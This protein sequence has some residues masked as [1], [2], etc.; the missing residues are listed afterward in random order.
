MESARAPSLPAL[1]SP[2]RS[3]RLLDGLRGR[4][5]SALLAEGLLGVAVGLAAAALLSFSLDYLLALPRGVRLVFLLG[6]AA[7]LVVALRRL[8]KV[9]RAPLSDQDLATIVERANPELSQA[10]LTAVE[11]SASANETAA[12]VSRDMVAAVVRDVEERIQGARVDGVLDARGQR[13]K[14]AALGVLLAVGFAGVLF[15]GDLVAIWLRRNLLLGAERWP[16]HTQ[17]VLVS[18]AV[19]DG[20]ILVAMGDDL[21]VIVRA[22]RGSPGSVSLRTYASGSLQRTDLLSP[23]A[24]AEYRALIENVSRPFSFVVQGGDDEIGPHEVDVRLRPRIDA[25]SIE[26]WCEYPAYT[27]IPPTPAAEPLRFANLK[28]PAGTKARY[29]MAASVPIRR[30]FFVFRPAPGASEGEG[31]VGGREAVKAGA[32]EPLAGEWP[33]QGAVELTVVEGKRFEGELD[34]THS[35]QYFFQLEAVDGFRSVRPDR[36]RVEA[37]P[38]LKPQARILEPERITEEVS[39]E[40]TIPVRVSA[41]DDYGLKQV[42]LEGRYFHPGKE[43]GVSQSFPF[44]RLTLEGRPPAED[45]EAAP[46]P[47]GA[48]TPAEDEVAIKIAALNTGGEGTVS[49]GARLQIYAL[50]ADLAGQIGESQIHFLN[51]V[52]QDDLLRILTDQ[53]MVVRDQLREVLRRQK[54]A[55][56]DLEDFQ[57]QIALLERIP[58]AEARRLGM[59][60]QDQERVTQ[61]TLREAQELSRVLARAGR[62]QVGDEK[63]RS[64]VSGVRDDVVEI[65]ERRSAGV[66]GM[67][68]TLQDEAT[69]SSPPVSRLGVIAAEQRGVERDIE[70]IIARLTEFGDVN[71]LIQMLRDLRRRQQELR[72]ETQ[73]RIQG[74][75]PPEEPQK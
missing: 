69:A 66:D 72:D 18:P 26:V 73:Q 1:P 60:R 68:R 52:E 10:L 35:G 64:W 40:A 75:K 5:R 16:K 46:G 42:V 27:S 53:L 45:G 56:K 22:E 29:R 48:K 74:K 30:A 49:P 33:D 25:Q 37:I 39:P 24:V 50:A 59:L 6:G 34:V 61:A 12:Y 70:S 54:S 2:E 63:W 4:L 9:L 43:T 19:E 51:V 28:V 32:A 20:P 47:I 14:G 62:N 44:P 41:S 21:E 67:L 55:R 57:G 3:L 11:L 15:Q 8:G 58:A 23:V 13:R 65:G 38:D 36:F 17:L 7:A 31:A 71:A